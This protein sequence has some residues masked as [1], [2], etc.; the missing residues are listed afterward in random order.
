M[1]QIILSKNPKQNKP[2]KVMLSLATRFQISLQKVERT[3]RCWWQHYNCVIF[4]IFILHKVF[5]CEKHLLWGFFYQHTR[6]ISTCRISI[7][8]VLI[9]ETAFTVDGLQVA[10]NSFHS[11]TQSQLMTAK[12]AKFPQIR[13]QQHLCVSAELYLPRRPTGKKV[14]TFSLS[15]LRNKQIS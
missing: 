7:C 4:Q 15:V 8:R 12:Y 13:I 11:R 5:L 10:T 3:T 2:T 9:Q 6:S 1:P 14:L